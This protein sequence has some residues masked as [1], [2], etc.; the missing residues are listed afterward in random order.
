MLV[1]TLSDR[2]SLSHSMTTL[3]ESS[4]IQIFKCI[5]AYT[6]CSFQAPLANETISTWIHSSTCTYLFCG[7]GAF[8]FSIR[9]KRS[10]YTHFDL[11]N[12]FL[13][14]LHVYFSRC[15]SVC[16]CTTMTFIKINKSVF[17]PCQVYL[18]T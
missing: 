12:L 3:T 9:F 16:G 14:S 4:N 2:F 13:Q 1:R 10:I 11:W 6:K 17:L 18:T 5:R 8:A 15:V 7:I